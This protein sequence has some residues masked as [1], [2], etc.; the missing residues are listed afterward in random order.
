VQAE[1]AIEGLRKAAKNRCRQLR[2]KD[3]GTIAANK[4]ITFN[5]AL[6]YRISK[7]I[8]GPEEG[9]ERCPLKHHLPARSCRSGKEQLLVCDRGHNSL[10]WFSTK[11]EL[12]RVLNLGVLMLEDEI[13]GVWPCNVAPFAGYRN[14][15]FD[16]HLAIARLF[17]V[18]LFLD[19]ADCDVSVVGGLPPTYIDGTLQQVDVFNYTFH[20]PHDVCVD[21]SGALYVAQWG[22]NRTYPIKL[23]LVS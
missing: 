21:A 13:I 3:Q 19:G 18:I 16:N 8:A 14:R 17:G 22:S 2:S 20:H 11:G 9:K 12:L 7:G 1:G 15:R 6:A 4:E 23:E 5:I 10:K